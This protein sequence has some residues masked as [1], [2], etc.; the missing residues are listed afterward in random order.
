M[1]LCM[2]VGFMTNAN[3]QITITGETDNVSCNSIPCP[4][5]ADGGIDLTV[6]GAA[7]PYVVEWSFNGTPIPDI[8]EEPAFLELDGIGATDLLGV[9]N[10]D[11][12]NAILTR[13]YIIQGS[14]LTVLGASFN[15]G[16]E[17]DEEIINNSQS[18]SRVALRTGVD[19]PDIIGGPNAANVIRSFTFNPP[20][21]NLNMFFNDMDNNDVVIVNPKLNGVTLPLDPSE[22]VIQDA[23]QVSKVTT[24]ARGNQD[25]NMFVSDVDQPLGPSEVGG[26]DFTF[27]GPI[28]EIEIIFYDDVAGPG[29][30]TSPDNV[31]K[32]WLVS[33]LVHILLL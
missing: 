20:V 1:M 23:S 2:S 11:V 9:D 22:Y 6:T 17:I 3:A 16:A 8:C 10:N 5:D 27:A 26:I 21:S 7:V 31:V 32:T 18:T 14:A 12:E 15:G 30:G 29:I 25:Q 28:D 19:H 13:N 4:P 33:K 24:D